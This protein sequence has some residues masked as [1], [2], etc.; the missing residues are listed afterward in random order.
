M[1]KTY[2][3]KNSVIFKDASLENYNF[4]VLKKNLGFFNH[5]SL[6]D[7]DID[8][9]AY[10]Q[11]SITECNEIMSFEIGDVLRIYRYLLLD[12]KVDDVFVVQIKRIQYNKSGRHAVLTIS[13]I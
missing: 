9:G 6:I 7:T 11:R 3:L 13:H 2:N 12:T 1:V 10:F 8:I 5:T 4:Y